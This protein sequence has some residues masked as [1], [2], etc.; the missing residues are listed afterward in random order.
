V[1]PSALGM[2]L[3]VLVTTVAP[4]YAATLDL[5]APATTAPRELGVQVGPLLLLQATTVDPAGGSTGL[6]TPE[7]YYGKWRGVRAL[8]EIVAFN[9]VMTLFGRWFM[10]EGSEGFVVSFES[11]HENLISGFEWDDNTFSANNF[12]HPYQGGMYFNAARANGYDFWASSMFS[13]AGSWLWEYTGENHHPSVN[14]WINTAVGGMALGEIT[15]RLSSIVLDNTATG[16][17]RVWRELGAALISPM[18]GLNRLLTGEA[19]ETHLNPPDRYPDT[20]TA[21]VAAGGRTLGSNQLWDSPSAKVFAAL[22]GSYG[23]PFGDIEHP[24]DYFDFGLQLNFNNKPHGIGRIG[25][26]GVLGS[27]ELDRG[28]DT[29]HRLAAYQN[30]DYLDNEAYTYGG[31]SFG[32]RLHSRFFK[33]DDWETRAGLQVN[34]IILGASKSDYNSISGR[35]YDYGPG[36]GVDFVAAF[37]RR[38]VDLLTI[39]H[40]SFYI[41]SVNGNEV[42]SYSNYTGVRV[43]VPLNDALRLRFDYLLFISRRDY[44]RHPDVEQQNPEL[45]A[46]L[47]WRL[48]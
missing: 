30:F 35:E 41:H 1:K 21:E 17:S 34:G 42:E 9:G 44:E 13:F 40:G 18:R 43:A 4:S 12:R 45:R 14:D 47:A 19:Y 36:A 48:N 2:A 23:D 15:Y 10:K 37:A 32:A 26:R 16:S 24:Y 39:S 33:G 8:G 46:A 27:V 11:I 6:R 28:E 3:L 31:Q 22:E 38:G 20:W 25:I 29:Q 7:S 5:G